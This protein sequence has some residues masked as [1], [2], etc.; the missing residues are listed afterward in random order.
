[1]ITCPGADD[2]PPTQQSFF[3]ACGR[4]AV[5]LP[6]TRD[7]GAAGCQGITKGGAQTKGRRKGEGK[8]E[9]LEHF[10]E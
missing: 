6:G 10:Q 3:A 9:D 1:M 8:G 7:H 5:H 2:D 4:H